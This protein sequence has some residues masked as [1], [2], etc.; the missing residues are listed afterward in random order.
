MAVKSSILVFYL[1][2]TRMH[3]E[4]QLI[5]YITVLIVNFTGLVF[6]ILFAFECRPLTI[7]FQPSTTITANCIDS[8]VLYVVSSPI[9]IATDIAIFLIPMPLL[10]RIQ[11]PRRQKVILVIT[12]STGLLV[13]AI[14]V[15][16]IAYLRTAAI[17][18]FANPAFSD[19]KTSQFNRY[20]LSCMQSRRFCHP[21]SLD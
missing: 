9:N 7:I 19:Q 17:A 5:I 10:T 14:G 21:D 4:F 13:I 2:L 15:L 16:R 1:T 8:I 6:T 20:D 18:R 12:F 11:L 3:T